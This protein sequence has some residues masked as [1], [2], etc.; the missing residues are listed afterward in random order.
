M[1]SRSPSIFVLFVRNDGALIL[2][3]HMVALPA[4]VIMS[5]SA[6]IIKR[7]KMSGLDF[8]VLVFQSSNR[9]DLNYFFQVLFSLIPTVYKGDVN[10]M[11]LGS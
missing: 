8:L 3:L 9:F 6:K 11:A 1:F 4:S 7:L 10:L 5:Y 2:S